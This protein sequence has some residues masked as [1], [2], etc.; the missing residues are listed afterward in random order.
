MFLLYQL[1]A[2]QSCIVGTTVNKRERDHFQVL[3]KLISY[4]TQDP[5]RKHMACSKGVIQETMMNK[6]MDRIKENN[7]KPYLG[8]QDCKVAGIPCYK[9]AKGDHVF[10]NPEKKLYTLEISE[11]KNYY[12]NREMQPRILTA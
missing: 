2:E 8:Q 3:M 1:H 11:H 7:G 6:D 4:I 12:L 10:W 5:S 9:G